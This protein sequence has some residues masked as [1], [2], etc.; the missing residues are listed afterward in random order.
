MPPRVTLIWQRETL[1]NMGTLLRKP[2]AEY[3]NRKKAK[4]L[5]SMTP[6]QV[7]AEMQQHVL[8]DGF[9]IVF[10]SKNSRGSKL[11]DAATGRE[12]VDLYS[13]YASQPI[14]FNHRYFERPDIEED[15]LDAAKVKLANS[16]VYSVHFA[17]FLRTFTRVMGLSPLNRY[18]LPMLTWALAARK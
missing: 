15:L 1:E 18:F 8:V 12:W 7:V 11:V 4:E 9:K 2:D 16:D 13:F 17:R 6:R 10:D 5:G 14:G 3:S